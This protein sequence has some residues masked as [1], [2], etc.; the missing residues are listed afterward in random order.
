MIMRPEQGGP[1]RYHSDNLASEFYTQ[2]HKPSFI[3]VVSTMK[4]W[5]GGEYVDAVRLFRPDL[6]YFPN[7]L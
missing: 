7:K 6:V 3:N 2:Q 5:Q 1:P 4:K